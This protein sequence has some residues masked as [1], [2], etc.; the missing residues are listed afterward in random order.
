MTARPRGAVHVRPRQIAEQH[1]VS[2]R[3]VRRWIAE[4]RID[5]VRVG[6]SVFVTVESV[7]RLFRSAR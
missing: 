5:S 4:R 7:E 2:E 1:G 6:R 3:T